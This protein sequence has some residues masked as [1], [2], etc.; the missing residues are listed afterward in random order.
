MLPGLSG[1]Y[2]VSREQ[3]MSKEVKFL[4]NFDNI[5]FSII[6]IRQNRHRNVRIVVIK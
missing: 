5:R 6:E 4:N 2:Y 3:P 1:M